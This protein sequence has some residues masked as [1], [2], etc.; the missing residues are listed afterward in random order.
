MLSLDLF[1][2]DAF[3][4]DFVLLL[5]QQRLLFCGGLR[6]LFL[7]L[8]L[9]FGLVLG[10]ELIV[11]VGQVELERLQILE[12][13]GAVALG[14]LNEP[15]RR[16]GDAVDASLAV[17]EP[18]LVILG[19]LDGVA[20]VL[21]ALALALGAGALLLGQ[22]AGGDGEEAVSL[23]MTFLGA[24]CAV[25]DRRRPGPAAPPAFAFDL[26]DRWSLPAKNENKALRR[27]PQ[28]V[29]KNETPNFIANLTIKMMA[30]IALTTNLSL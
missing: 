23:M 15:V 6:L 25:L 28:K 14:T 26:A 5:L 17:A 19:G 18:V 7:P 12:L 11:R 4:L 21:E 8:L 27:V 2:L 1:F 22:G 9:H 30:R 13:L 29:A 24:F 16:A 10:L 20:G 3:S